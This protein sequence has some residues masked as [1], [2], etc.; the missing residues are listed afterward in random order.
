MIIETSRREYIARQIG[1]LGKAIL[2]VGL[3]SYFFEKFPL[4]VRI[5]LTLISFAFLI[6]GVFIQPR[7]KG[8]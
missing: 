1:D 3:A 7:K 5:S 6:I 2:T 8:E 4:T